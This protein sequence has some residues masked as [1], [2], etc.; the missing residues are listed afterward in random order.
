MKLKEYQKH[1]TDE[2]TSHIEKRQVAFCGE[3]ITDWAFTGVS[4]MV[5]CLQ[6]EDRLLPCP[7][8]KEKIMQIF[9]SDLQNISIN[10][11]E[12]IK[13]QSTLIE[14]LAEAL[15]EGYTH[16]DE[17]IFGEGRSLKEASA[18]WKV[19]EAALQLHADYINNSK[20]K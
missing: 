17:Q 15:K 2:R 6:T 9:N 5:M 10:K 7:K 18:T 11:T 19:L 16:I 4:H 3:Q 14:K 20:Q 13:D 12:T 8:C 1:V